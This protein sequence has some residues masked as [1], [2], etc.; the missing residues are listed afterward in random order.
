VWT[1]QTWVVAAREAADRGDRRAAIRCAYWAAV[2]RLQD[3]RLLPQDLTRTPREYLGLI[4]RHD[5]TQPSLAALTSAL[6]RFWYAGRAANA[7]D[8]RES[9]NHLEALGCRLD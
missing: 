1:W 2:V 3:L 8:F 6:E 4:P 5:D 9:V 7:D